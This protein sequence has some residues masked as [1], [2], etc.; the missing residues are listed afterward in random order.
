MNV[1]QVEWHGKPAVAIAYL[2]DR[3]QVINITTFIIFGAVLGTGLALLPKYSLLALIP[4]PIAGIITVDA[5]RQRMFILMDGKKRFLTGVRRGLL[6]TKELYSVQVVLIKEIR[7]EDSTAKR[8]KVEGP[9][10]G[11]EGGMR[12][13]HVIAM[14]RNS[15]D[16][17]CATSSEKTATLVGHAVSR[18]IGK[19]FGGRINLS[20][21]RDYIDILE[22]EEKEAL[23]SLMTD[24]R[25]H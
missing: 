20:H 4:V 3:Q 21:W 1:R 6:F 17:L 12:K 22:E 9:E 10:A 18:A 8:T 15:D 23:G 5:L 25:K 24:S 7:L 16:L 14:G 13:F 11:K 19:R 2:S